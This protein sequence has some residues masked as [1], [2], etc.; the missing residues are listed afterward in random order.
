MKIKGLISFT[1]VLFFLLFTATAVSA[2]S[3]EDRPSPPRTAKGTIDGVNIIIDYSSPGVKGR[4]I[5]GGLV[6][7]DEVWRTGANEATTI[8]FDKDVMVNGQKLAKGKYGLF[9]IPGKDSWI[10]IF[11]KVWDQWGAFHYNKEEDVLRINAKPDKASA[12]QE[13]MIFKVDSA[14][15][16]VILEWENLQVS[17][18]VTAD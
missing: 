8:S 1:G 6:P 9:T 3:K 4:T 17:F 12:F 5:W 18:K 16:R 2:Q 10:W 13:R 7:Y 15:Q 14:S 11:N